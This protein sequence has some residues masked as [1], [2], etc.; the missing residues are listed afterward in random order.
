MPLVSYNYASGNIKRMQNAVTYSM[1]L[2]LGFMAAVVIIYHF[3]AEFWI[4][5]FMDNETVIAYGASFLQGMCLAL[6]FLCVDF[7]AVGIFQACG[8]GKKAL[9]FALLR[10]IVFEIPALF[11][12]NWLFPM[13]GLA[14]AQFVAEVILSV[15][16]VVV[17]VRLFRDLKKKH[18]V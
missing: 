6:P 3:G 8:M 17:L 7:I 9:V 1:K 18:Q 14:Y 15:V 11:V 4:S 13:Y 12:L 5:L 2:A 16:A 10:K